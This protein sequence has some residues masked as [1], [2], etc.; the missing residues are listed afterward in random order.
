MNKD[1]KGTKQ[2]NR[3]RIKRTNQKQAE[4]RIRRMKQEN[5]ATNEENDTKDRTNKR[6]QAPFRLAVGPR[7]L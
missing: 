3:Q 2:V 5:E 1:N 6:S 4:E 7:K